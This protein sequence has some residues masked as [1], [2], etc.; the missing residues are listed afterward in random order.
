MAKG[1]VGR[2]HET[3]KMMSS[4]E[5][6]RAVYKHHAIISPP[7]GTLVDVDAPERALNAA[8]HTIR[9]ILDVI[10]AEGFVYYHPLSGDAEHEDDRGKWK[11]RLFNDR[12]W[13]DVRA[14]LEMR[15]HFHLVVCTPHLPGGDVTRAIHE[16]T[17]WLLHRITERNGS[18]ISLGDLD[19]V[20]RAVT[21]C[22]SHTGI[23]ERANGNYRAAQ[24]CYGPAPHDCLPVDEET[25]ELATYACHQAAPETLGLSTENIECRQEMPEDERTELDEFTPD[26][27]DGELDETATSSTIETAG[28][29]PCGSALCSVDDADR[30]LDDPD[31][32]QQARYVDEARE[33]KQAWEA[34]GGWQNWLGWED[35]QPD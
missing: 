28:T 25:D 34:A 29:V 20:A 4:R 17:G 18:P 12:E 22:L 15:P 32:C 1:H 33:T 3:A 30:L 35:T 10:G 23:E 31:W 27:G 14:E 2:L 6:N 5:S 19:D 7:P 16:R 9:D 24:R 26:S 13:S 8:F 21:Y 11:K